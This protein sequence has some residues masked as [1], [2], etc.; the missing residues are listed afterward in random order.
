M[1]RL[2]ANAAAEDEQLFPTR[3]YGRA[4]AQRREYDDTPCGKLTHVPSSW[5]QP[6]AQ[7]CCA[8]KDHRLSEPLRHIQRAFEGPVGVCV[9]LSVWSD[10]NLS[11]IRSDVGEN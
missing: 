10:S 9:R 5:R 11:W 4:L 2:K 8:V 3:V 1:P 7:S 6:Y